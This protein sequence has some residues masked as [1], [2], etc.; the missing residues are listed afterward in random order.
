M[1]FLEEHWLL[2]GQTGA[3]KTC[4]LKYRAVPEALKVDPGDDRPRGVIIFDPFGDTWQGDKRYL[5]VT[6]NREKFYKK[7]WESTD[8]LVIFDEAGDEGRYDKDLETL[9]VKGRHNRH[10]VIFSAQRVQQLNTTVRGQCKKIIC[11]HLTPRDSEFLAKEWGEERLMTAQTLPP[12]HY[13]VADRW[14][15]VTKSKIVFPQEKS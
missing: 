14:G 11:F 15:K 5:F 10:D 4:Y 9:A 3:G 6:D 8:K 12:L 1:Q 13:I 2:Y 7:V